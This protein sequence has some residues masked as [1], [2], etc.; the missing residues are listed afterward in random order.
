M[1][2]RTL[3]TYDRGKPNLERVLFEVV[4]PVTLSYY[5]VMHTTRL[6][7]GITSGG[8]PAFW[9]PTVEAPVGET[10]QLFTG[11]NLTEK[12]AMPGNYFWGLRQTIL[13]TPNDC[14]VLMQAA[15]WQTIFEPLIPTTPA[16]PGLWPQTGHLGK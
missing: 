2:L 12:P 15:T 1:S 4:A 9:F 14:L 7:D 3:G 10:I 6:G 13:N 5:I 11:S 8:H 16:L